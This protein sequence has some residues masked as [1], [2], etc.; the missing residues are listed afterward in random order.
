MRSGDSFSSSW[1]SRLFYDIFGVSPTH[2]TPSEVSLGHLFVCDHGR[3]FC[4][5]SCYGQD[6]LFFP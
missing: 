1:N 5:I 3:V 6:S 2:I 4:M